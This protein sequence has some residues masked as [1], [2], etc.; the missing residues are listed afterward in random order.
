MLSTDTL[1]TLSHYRYSDWFNWY[2]DCSDIHYIHGDS[3][4]GGTSYVGVTNG[5]GQ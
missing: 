5:A 3:S 4:N 2:Y 1:P